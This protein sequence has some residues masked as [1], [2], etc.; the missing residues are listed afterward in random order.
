MKAAQWWKSNECVWSIIKYEMDSAQM[1]PLLVV[2]TL[3]Q[4]L[5]ASEQRLPVSQTVALPAVPR[6]RG[7]LTLPWRAPPGGK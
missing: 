3:C 6:T 1:P 4:A 2:C 5:L 7:I